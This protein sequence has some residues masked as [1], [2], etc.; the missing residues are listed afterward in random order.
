M[1]QRVGT[2][3]SRLVSKILCPGLCPSLGAQPPSS[4][5][6]LPSVFL[7][8]RSSNPTLHDSQGMGPVS[9]P[10]REILCHPAI[11]L[12]ASFTVY[13]D[14]SH[15][16][17]YT[18]LGPQSFRSDNICFLLFYFLCS[19][20]W[21]GT[22]SVGQTSLKLTEICLPMC[23]RAGVKGEHHQVWSPSVYVCVCACICRC[24]CVGYTLLYMCMRLEVDFRSLVRLS[25][26]LLIYF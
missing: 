9:K 16:R 14:E 18:F 1:R 5:L 25:L 12:A 4:L 6:L 2:T 13:S 11:L 15:K 19:H 10:V 24:M 3:L 20:G 22:H 26:S 17:N 8:T 23:L 21:T 7:K